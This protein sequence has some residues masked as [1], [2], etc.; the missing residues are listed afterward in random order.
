MPSPHSDSVRIRPYVPDDLDFMYRVCLQ[1]AHAGTDATGLYRDPALPGEIYM[2]PYARFEPSLAFVAEDEEGVGG[3]IVAALDSR[4]FERRLVRDWWPALRDRYPEPPDDVAA[5][6]SLP[7][8]Y[9]LH[10]IHHPW[11][12]ADDLFRRFPSHLH[13]NL[14]PRLQG[15]GM[16]RQLITTLSAA[17]RRRGSRGVHLVVGRGNKRAVSFYR[18]IGFTAYPSS[19]VE[20]FTMDLSGPQAQ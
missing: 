19:D 8:R 6:L 18:H 9:A 4:A 17:L 12:T 5:D 15:R 10:D 14:L 13:I 1:T 20:I 16:G 2:A 3:Y 11:T 7:E